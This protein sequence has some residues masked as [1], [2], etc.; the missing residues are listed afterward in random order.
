MLQQFIEQT[1]C[2]RRNKVGFTESIDFSIN[3]VSLIFYYS[4]YNVGVDMFMCFGAVAEK[5]DRKW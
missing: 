2:Q 1:P 3:T 4:L 5:T